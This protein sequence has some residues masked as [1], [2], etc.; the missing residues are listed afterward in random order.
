MERVVSDQ[1]V[2]LLRHGCSDAVILEFLLREVLA[3]WL[4]PFLLGVVLVDCVSLVP[5]VLLE[6]LDDQV[7]VVNL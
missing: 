7:D 3:T 4:V 1:L 5:V 2:L 6:K